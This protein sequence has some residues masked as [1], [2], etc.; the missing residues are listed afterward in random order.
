MFLPA[1]QLTVGLGG[2][3]VGPRGGPQLARVQDLSPQGVW[4]LRQTLCMSCFSICERAAVISC[5]WISAVARWQG[6]QNL[7][8]LDQNFCQILW[9]A[10]TVPKALSMNK[11]LHSPSS[12]SSSSARH[13]IEMTLFTCHI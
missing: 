3:G 10:S 4:D 7:V 8:A 13:E 12:S 5:H 6:E 1:T 9:R 11:D 2:R